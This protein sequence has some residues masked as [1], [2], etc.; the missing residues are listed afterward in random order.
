M[1]IHHIHHIQ[2]LQRGNSTRRKL[3][4]SMARRRSAL[5]RFSDR[6]GGLGEDIIQILN[7]RMIKTKSF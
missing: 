5:S 6:H 3:H 1:N 2:A 7:S 4:T